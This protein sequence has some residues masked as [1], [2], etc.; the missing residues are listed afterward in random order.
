MRAATLIQV[1]TTKI[2]CPNCGAATGSLGHLLDGKSHCFGPWYCDDCGREYHGQVDTD[3]SV[4]IRMG[5]SF[6][7]KSLNVLAINPQETPI[8][9][10][11][12]GG[13]PVNPDEPRDPHHGGRYY[14]EEHSCPTNFVPVE[15]ISQDGDHDPHGIFTYLG[16]VDRPNDDS[17]DAV[18]KAVAEF[19]GGGKETGE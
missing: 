11:V 5:K 18:I 9:F 3:G 12:E 19:I 14:Y 17:E 1:T 7:V 4:Q 2:G 15:L 16:S 8:Y 10:V 13:E 6:W